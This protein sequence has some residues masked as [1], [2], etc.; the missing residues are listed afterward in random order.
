MKPLDNSKK[1]LAL[2]S[3][4]LFEEMREEDLIIWGDRILEYSNLLESQICELRLHPRTSNKVEWPK[5][6]KKYLKIEGYIINI[7]D[8][9]TY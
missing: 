2:F 6:L 9:N 3:G 7:N 1:M 4:C 8:S 5:K